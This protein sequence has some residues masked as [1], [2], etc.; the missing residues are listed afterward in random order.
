MTAGPMARA[1]SP[2]NSEER[3]SGTSGVGSAAVV[4]WAWA[5]GT[6][7]NDAMAAVATTAPALR[8]LDMSG[9]R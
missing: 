6:K 1:G 4:S 5:W 7:P 3:I 9:L 2:V 8:T